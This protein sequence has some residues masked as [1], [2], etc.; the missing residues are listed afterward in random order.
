M[1]ILNSW[2]SEKSL[3]L[4]PSSLQI[5]TNKCYL[6]HLEQTVVKQLGYKA[7]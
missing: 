2:N 5:M 1:G 6:F 3:A 7:I 4:V